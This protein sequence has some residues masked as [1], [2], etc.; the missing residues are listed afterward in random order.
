MKKL[1][2]IPVFTPPFLWLVKLFSV[3]LLLPV[4]L[5]FSLIL[6]SVYI[7]RKSSF[8]KNEVVWAWI[9]WNVSFLA[10]AFF[11]F[12]F[13]FFDLAVGA[14]SSGG[15]YQYPFWEDG[16]YLFSYPMFFGIIFLGQII[17]KSKGLKTHRLTDFVLLLFLIL[18]LAIAVNYRMSIVAEENRNN[19]D[20]RQNE[21]PV[22]MNVNGVRTRL[23]VDD[24][25]T[26]DSMGCGG[27]SGFR[28]W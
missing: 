23:G 12:V 28:L 15:G 9:M 14:E 13:F 7:Y 25:I 24:L 20:N 6:I 5:V 10:I 19:G 27:D 2:C 1:Y 21:N 4:L 18:S 17:L 8:G 22:Y 11:A 26:A 16:Y 3:K